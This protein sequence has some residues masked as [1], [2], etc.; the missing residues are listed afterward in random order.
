MGKKIMNESAVLFFQ[1]DNK[2]VFLIQACQ[3]GMEFIAYLLAS[4][5]L[6]I[7]FSNKTRLEG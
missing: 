3:K 6:L 5:L 7:A 2:Q 4:V 1:Y